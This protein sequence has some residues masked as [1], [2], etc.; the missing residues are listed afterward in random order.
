MKK[1]IRVALFMVLRLA[2]PGD[3]ESF[4]GEGQSFCEKR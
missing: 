2:E 1:D 4:K 3:R